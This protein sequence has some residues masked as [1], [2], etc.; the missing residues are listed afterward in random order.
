MPHFPLE[1]KDGKNPVAIMGNFNIDPPPLCADVFAFEKQTGHN[2][3]Y[4]VVWQYQP[5]TD[6]CTIAIQSVIAK[7]YKLIYENAEVLKLY[8]RN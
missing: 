7:N 4:I 2:I 5:L 8:K 6:T 1:W 3:D